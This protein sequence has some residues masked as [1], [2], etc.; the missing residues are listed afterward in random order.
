MDLVGF[1]DAPGEMYMYLGFMTMKIRA[2]SGLAVEMNHVLL[3]GCLL[4]L[5]V[6]GRSLH[7]VR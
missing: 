1:M 6:F 5:I 2:N 3:D 4:V 7:R